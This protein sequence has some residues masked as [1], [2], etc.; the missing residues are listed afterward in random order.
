MVATDG[1]EAK[2]RAGIEI[3]VATRSDARPDR[4]STYNYRPVGVKVDATPQII[5]ATH[6]SRMKHPVLDRLQGGGRA[7][8]SAQFR[9]GSHEVRA[10]VFESGKPVIVTQAADGETGREGT[11]Q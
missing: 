3:A 8:I 9:Q 7:G 4:P 11:V 5:D 6:G 10:I 1:R 2:G